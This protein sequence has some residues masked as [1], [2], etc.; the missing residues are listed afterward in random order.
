MFSN[1]YGPLLLGLIFLLLL[2]LGALL[3]IWKPWMRVGMRDD[4]LL[5]DSESDDSDQEEPQKPDGP[6]LTV[7]V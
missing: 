3:W 1:E 2:L 6:R 5:T 4:S 7:I